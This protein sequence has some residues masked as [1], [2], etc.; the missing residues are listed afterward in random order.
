[1]SHPLKVKSTSSPSE[2]QP[3]KS[4]R[5]VVCSIIAMALLR[6]TIDSTI[7]G[8]AL[9]T[10]QQDLNTTVRWVGWPITAYSFGFVLMLPVSAKL[11]TRFGHRRIFTAS[12]LLFTIASLLC[13]LSTHIY[14]LII[15]RVF[16]AM[17]SE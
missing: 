10:L 6:N 16:Q 15:M 9:N 14:T 5:G 1:M 12:V 13:G 2:H 11:S 4:N 3:V 8:T 7:V 17:R